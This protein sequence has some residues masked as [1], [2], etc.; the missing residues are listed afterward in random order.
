MKEVH[1]LKDGDQK[2]ETK[3]VI[4]QETAQRVRQWLVQSSKE[5][6]STS[7]NKHPGIY[8]G[9][10]SLILGQESDSKYNCVFISFAPA[11]NPQCCI[12]IGADS[13]MGEDLVSGRELAPIAEKIADQL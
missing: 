6:F 13:N 5:G 1:F 7:R 12:V 2:S 10:G 8:G 9:Y 3:Q 11:D 4:S